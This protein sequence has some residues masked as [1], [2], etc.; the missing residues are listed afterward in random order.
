MVMLQ[1]YPS[2][3]LYVHLLKPG[4]LPGEDDA[5][6]GP[7]VACIADAGSARVPAV[8]VNSAA[9]SWDGLESALKD[10]LK[11]RAKWVVYVETEPNV[12]WA[13]VANAVDAAKGLHATVVLA[14]IRRP[15]CR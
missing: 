6:A 1:P 9:T 14:D 2:K 8:Y 13:H 5:L 10:Q 12:N 15:T 4:H 11:L 7:V 3:G